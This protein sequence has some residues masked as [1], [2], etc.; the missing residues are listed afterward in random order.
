M[1]SEN[2]KNNKKLLL[3]AG[4]SSAMILGGTLAYFTTSN[5]IANSL[6]TGLYQHSIVETFESPTNWTPGTTTNKTVKVSNNG[7]VPMALR[8]SYTERWVNNKGEDLPL[9]DGE[10]IAT[11]INFN[12]SWTKSDD[13]YFYYGSKES[14]TSLDANETSTSF[15]DSITFNKDIEGSFTTTTSEDGKT[16]TVVSSGEGY[17]NAQYYLTITIDTVQYDQAANIWN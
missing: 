12:N 5:D 14:L 4:I 13:G 17:D 11:V 8:A 9:K 2:K 3:I 6:R 7:N 15:I 10:T 16:I 1:K